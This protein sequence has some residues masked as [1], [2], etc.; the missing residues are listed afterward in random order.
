ML[1][2]NM[3]SDIRDSSD[4]R[5]SVLIPAYNEEAL[6][7]A[8]IDRVHES[9]N[10]L[11]FD[12]Y[13]IVVCDNN[14]TDATAR[15]AESKRARVVFEPHNQIARARNAAARAARGDWFIFLDA[16]TF[17]TADVLADTIQCFE[18]GTIAGGGSI[19]K[20]DKEKLSAFAKAMTRFWNKIS[21]VL[22]L[23]AG[24]YLF[25]LRDAWADVGGFDDEIYAGEELFFSRKLKK[26]A[27]ARGMR[28]TILTR[29]PVVTSARK[30]EW[31]DQWQLMA[32]VLSMARPGAVK[33]RD[34]CRLWYTRPTG[35]GR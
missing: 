25:C 30:I 27:R 12:S 21:V 11:S 8:V 6:I 1:R 23:A 15:L 2:S 17:L 28:F 4:P 35:D 29:S 18:S 20:F 13:E 3:P 14:S 7:P 19:L 26:W 9:F 16:D 31:Y 10:A 34:L 24:S 5:V 33:R 22:R 32:H